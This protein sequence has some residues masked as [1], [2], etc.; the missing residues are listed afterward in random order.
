MH[1]AGA[2]RRSG[3][4]VGVHGKPATLHPTLL[5][6]LASGQLD[7]GH[8]ITHRF[9]FDDFVEAYRTFADPTHTDALKVVLSRG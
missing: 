7:V 8:M 6:M 3:A 9:G 1:D 4:N 2:A 5:R